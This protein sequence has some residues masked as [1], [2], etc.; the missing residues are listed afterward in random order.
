MF[1]PPL[2]GLSCPAE[3][4][5]LQPVKTKTRRPVVSL[6]TTRMHRTHRLCRRATLRPDVPVRRS[7]AHSLSHRL[8]TTASHLTVR[9]ATFQRDIDV[10][11]TPGLVQY[12]SFHHA[13][14]ED[15]DKVTFTVN[16]SSQRTA[17]DILEVFNQAAER[18]I[19]PET[20]D[21]PAA[22]I[23]DMHAFLHDELNI[24]S[25]PPPPLSL[26]YSALKSPDDR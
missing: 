14:S 24:G 15:L 22:T 7:P 6:S 2:A 13:D 9:E 12:I 18:W 1:A 26:S 23:R 4:I 25:L 5:K 10:L 20:E 19:T 3:S 21:G 17:E 16:W 11:R 8:T